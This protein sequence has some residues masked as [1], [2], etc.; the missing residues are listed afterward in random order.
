MI[1]GAPLRALRCAHRSS[2]LR[3]AGCQYSTLGIS[4]P[5]G[6]TAEPMEPAETETLASE[7]ADDLDDEALDLVGRM[8][9]CP[10]CYSAR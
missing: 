2:R 10:S 6:S 4:A 1:A 8:R 3:P 5:E 9:A 7:F